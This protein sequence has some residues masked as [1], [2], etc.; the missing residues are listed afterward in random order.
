MIIFE[1]FSNYG[2]ILYKKLPLLLV[3]CSF[4][5]AVNFNIVCF[6]FFILNI[7]NSVR[8]FWVYIFVISFLAMQTKSFPNYLSKWCSQHLPLKENFTWFSVSDPHC[9]KPFEKPVL[10]PE[11]WILNLRDWPVTVPVPV[12]VKRFLE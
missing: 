7:P 9:E 11:S 4:C 6:V 3:F 1:A 5:L 8:I 10:V 12:T 2:H